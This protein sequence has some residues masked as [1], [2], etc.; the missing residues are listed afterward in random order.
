M[1]CQGTGLKEPHVFYCSP[2]EISSGNMC[3]G[4]WTG[5]PGPSC[6]QWSSTLWETVMFRTNTVIFYWVLVCE[7]VTS[8][9]R[10]WDWG[11]V[12]NTECCLNSCPRYIHLENSLCIH[13][14]DHWGPTILQPK[15]KSKHSQREWST[16]DMRGWWAKTVLEGLNGGEQRRRQMGDAR[17]ANPS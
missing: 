11:W 5:D 12:G 9:G 2:E 16:C 3:I 17:W 14:E 15:L 4:E 1:S 10:S 6:F 13:T 8:Y 7:G